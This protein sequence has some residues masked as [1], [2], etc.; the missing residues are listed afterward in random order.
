M[1][2]DMRSGTVSVPA[3]CCPTGSQQILEQLPARPGP[4]Q[5]PL[6]PRVLSTLHHP[7]PRAF[8]TLRPWACYSN[9]CAGGASTH[10][11]RTQDPL[12]MSTWGWGDCSPE[13]R[14]GHILQPGG[15]PGPGRCSRPGR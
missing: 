3:R 14:R 10:L 12:K 11:Q 8:H 5:E 7:L 6:G 4:S 15:W 2:P 13:S 9:L 1:A